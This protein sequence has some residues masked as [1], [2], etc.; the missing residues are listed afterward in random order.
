MNG[1]DETDVKRLL[2]SFDRK[3]GEC[4]DENQRDGNETSVIDLSNESKNFVD[5]R[6]FLEGFHDER[7]NRV[8]I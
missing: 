5:V 6:G 3:R 8:P 4:R 1:E 7:Q 2:G